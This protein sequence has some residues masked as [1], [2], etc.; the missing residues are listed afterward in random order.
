MLATRPRLYAG[1][2]PGASEEARRVKIINANWI[3]DA[4]GEDR[5][6]ELMIMT[7][8]T[9]DT[10]APSPAAITALVALAQAETVL[11][12]DPADRKADCRQRARHDVLGGRPS[13]AGT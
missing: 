2:V 5:R 6:L 7:R 13:H 11:V 9:V 4:D 12:R 8:M 3:A 10:S 1:N